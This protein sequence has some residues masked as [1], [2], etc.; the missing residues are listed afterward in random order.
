MSLS[1]TY[2]FTGRGNWSLDA[3]AGSATDGGTIQTFV[4][5]GST[6]VR[7][8]LYETT[9]STSSPSG[10]TLGSGL[11]SLN[12][13]A[14]SFT[15]LGTTAGLQAYRTDVTSYISSIVGSGSAEEFSFSTSN[16]GSGVDGFA[17]AV[18]FSNPNEAERTIVFADGFSATT[19]DAFD[20]TFPE[21]IDTSEPGFEALL[22]LG[23]GFSYQAGGVQQY[24]Q[25]D[26]NGERL[27]TSAG[28]EDDGVSANGGLITIG[29]LGDSSDNPA[30]PS[31]TPTNPRSDDEL[32]DLT[33]GFIENGATKLTVSTLNPS[34]DD[35]I[36]FAGFNILG[37]AS[38]NTG[39]NDAP[40]AV[41]DAFA[42]TDSGLNNV[43]V[44]ANDSDPDG[45]ALTVTSFVLSNNFSGTV[46]FNDDNTFNFNP[47]GFVGLQ[48]FSYTISDPDGLTATAMVT[49]TVEEDDTPPPPIDCPS[50]DRVGTQ[51]GSAATNDL[52][53]GPGYY[54]TF[55]FDVAVASGD[56]RISNFAKNDIIVTSEAIYDSNNDGVIK[57]GKNSMLDL[58]DGDTVKIDGIA[59]SSGLRFMGEYC[60]GS[61]VYADAL[62]RPKGAIEGKFTNDILTGDELNTRPD[63]FFFDTA[64]GLSLGSDRI[65]NF[66]VNDVVVTTTAIRDGNSDARIGFGRNGIIDL[67]GGVGSP[68]GP[69]AAGAGGTLSITGT[70]ADKLN[71]LEFDGQVTQNGVIY[72]V[73]S[74]VGSDGG[75]ETLSF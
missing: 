64:L 70:A 40:F 67:P 45:D 9:F 28:G 42:S 13:E 23:I 12:I 8:L 59:G 21:P 11:S 20:I 15:A 57:F 75:I 50:V 10:V 38:I 29:G 53:T 72:Y 35:N 22:S 62:V 52:M 18:V 19:G 2:T 17:L 14:G 47:Q 16:L 54:N 41:N 48:T 31:T 44:L 30:S 66:G 49:L 63:V 34:N 68:D 25:V 56:D 7:A 60:E 32:Y 27:T 71:V 3:S 5:V 58:G 4:P 26:I 73:Y 69:S 37:Q 61:F 74:S 1:S 65:I 6:V 36:F 39:N 46:S 33:N 55:F 43:S 24:S 51:D